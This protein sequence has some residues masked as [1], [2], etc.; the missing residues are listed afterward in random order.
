MSVSR[1]SPASFLKHAADV[2][3]FYGFCPVREI[4]RHYAS[5]RE[6]TGETFQKVR[7]QHSFATSSMLCAQYANLRPQEPLLVFYATPTPTF[8][9]IGATELSPREIGEFGLQV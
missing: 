3:L 2:A 7:G 8:L 9:P 4:E 1:V 6:H 5:Y